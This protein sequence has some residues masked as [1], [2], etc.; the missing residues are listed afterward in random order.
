M[1][2]K[3]ILNPRIMTETINTN[4]AEFRTLSSLRDTLPPKLLS[5]EL[6]AARIESQLET[7]T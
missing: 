5:G 2:T 4:T 6:S 7:V 3:K 1:A